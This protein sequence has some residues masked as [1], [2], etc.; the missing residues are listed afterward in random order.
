VHSSAQRGSP[1]LTG[2]RILIVEDDFLLARS[3]DRTLSSAGA[4]IVGP[5]ASS[6]AALQMFE[7]SATDV[8]LLDIMLSKGTSAEVA[9]AMIA[10]GCPVLFLTGFHTRDMLPEELRGVPCLEK[11]VDRDE[12]LEALL[13]VSDDRR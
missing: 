13:L 3:L 5:V 7:E 9:H 10:A 6:E 1:D 2:L 4:D 8:G 11:P 12:L